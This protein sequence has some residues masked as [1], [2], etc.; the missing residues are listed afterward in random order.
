MFH[1]GL[2]FPSASLSTSSSSLNPST[3][4]LERTLVLYKW[5]KTCIFRDERRGSLYRSLDDFDDS[6]DETENK[7]LKTKKMYDAI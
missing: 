4:K 7:R 5:G 2:G 6:D 3:G 1:A